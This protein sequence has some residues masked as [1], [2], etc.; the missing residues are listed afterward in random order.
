M[1]TGRK[2]SAEEAVDWGLVA[3]LVPHDQLLDAATEVLAECLMALD[4][5]PTAL[6]PF[7][8][9]LDGRAK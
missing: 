3:R 5:L 4:S 1:F 9:L 6:L 8:I 7:S 2:L